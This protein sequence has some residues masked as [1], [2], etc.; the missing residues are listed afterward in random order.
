[1][2]SCKTKQNICIRH[3]TSKVWVEVTQK[4]RLHFAESTQKGSLSENFG[5]S[6]FLQLVSMRRRNFTYPLHFDDIQN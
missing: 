4:P 6:W 3:E 1:M 2:D 5:I